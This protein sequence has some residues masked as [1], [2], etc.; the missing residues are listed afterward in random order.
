MPLYRTIPLLIFTTFFWFLSTLVHADFK[1]GMDA[2]DRGD[3]EAAIKEI[4]PL[5]EQGRADAQFNLGVMYANG[6]GESQDHA[7]AV[8]WYRLAAEQ[9]FVLAQYNLGLM[10]AHGQGVPQDYGEA[11]RWYRLAAE[12]GD[13]DAQLNLGVMYVKGQ[14]V[15][16]D[17]VQAHMWAN[18]GAAQGDKDSAMLRDHLVEIMTFEQIAEAQRLAREW[19]AQHQK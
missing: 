3:Y 12:Q 17:Y 13:A 8:R 6:Q 5:A 16:Q 4:R 10:Y 18:L 15:L 2:Y 1:A 9:G 14:G 7:E 19:L 11:L